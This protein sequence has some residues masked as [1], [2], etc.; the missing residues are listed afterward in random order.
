MKGRIDGSQIHSYD[1]PPGTHR[2]RSDLQKATG[3]A[4]EIHH[5]LARPQQPVLLLQIQ[6]LVGRARAVALALRA[7]VEVVFA[8]GTNPG[9]YFRLRTAFRIPMTASR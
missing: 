1:D 6:E 5:A 2:L 9:A 3:P 7:L 8:V 4:A